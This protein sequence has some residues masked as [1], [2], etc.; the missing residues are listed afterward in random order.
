M[1]NKILLVGCGNMGNA[2]LA[3]WRN[4]G[5]LTES[6]VV[7]PT[8]AHAQEGVSFVSDAAAI[9]SNFQPNII[10]L[11]VKPQVL[12][13]VLPAYAH[14]AGQVPFLSIAA[15]KTMAFLERHIGPQAAIVR[16][17]PNLP[18][19][20]GRGVSA[21]CANAAATQAHRTI[22]TALLQAVGSVRWV[23]ESQIDAITALS[24]SG[25]AYVFLLAE[26]M[27]RAGETLGL[28][29]D[30]AATL[31]RETIAGAAE[32]LHRSPDPAEA[33]RTRVTSKGGTTEAALR[34]L[35]END[36]LFSIY[37]RAMQAAVNRAGELA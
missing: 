33:L 25:P 22:A 9:P 30:L 20:V 31:A 6:Y 27:A 26:T 11:A 17:M 7:E 36:A 29:P 28:P 13:E 4:A 15:G 8:L 21:C 3:G 14:F 12:A 18:V 37:A 32:M 35:L 19:T 34:I 2:L 10:V 23:E 24:G 16:A 5:L 1:I